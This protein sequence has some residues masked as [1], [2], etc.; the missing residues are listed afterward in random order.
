M[1]VEAWSLNS[2][3][4]AMWFSSRRPWPN[5][6]HLLSSGLGRL[7]SRTGPLSMFHPNNVSLP[8]PARLA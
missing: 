3:S 6:R 5:S 7:H 2:S 1:H 4:G 8:W